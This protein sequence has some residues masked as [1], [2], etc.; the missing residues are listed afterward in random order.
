MRNLKVPS[1]TKNSGTYLVNSNERILHKSPTDI[2]LVF[3][4]S[5]THGSHENNHLIQ[6]SVQIK[7]KDVKVVYTMRV[8]NVIFSYDVN[9]HFG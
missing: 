5:R 6:H 1:V 9:R 4:L 7:V 3:N 8:L 2:E